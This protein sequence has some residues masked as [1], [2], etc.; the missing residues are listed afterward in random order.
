MKTAAVAALRKAGI[1]P[2]YKEKLFAGFEGQFIGRREPAKGV[3]VSATVCN[4]LDRS[5]FDLGGPEHIQ[6]LIPQD[7]RSFRIQAAASF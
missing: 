2:L 7:G 4:L 6:E 1:A 3:N 5:C